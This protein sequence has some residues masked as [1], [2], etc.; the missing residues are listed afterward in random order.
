MILYGIVLMTQN[1]GDALM[2]KL[3]VVALYAILI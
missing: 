3:V 1:V 2:R